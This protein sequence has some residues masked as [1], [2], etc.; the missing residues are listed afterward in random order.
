M[1]PRLGACAIAIGLAACGTPGEPVATAPA[2]ARAFEW[3]ELAS[4]PSARTEVA[5]AVDGDGLIVVVGGFAPDTVAT[6]EIYDPSTDRWVAGPA[7]PIAVNHAMAASVDGVVHVFGGYTS[8]GAPSNQAFALRGGSWETLPV[9]PEGRAAGG[10]A[11]AGGLVY[12]AG[13]VGP[14]GLAAS[15]LIFDPSTDAWTSGPALLRPREH[16]GVASVGSSVYAVG[17]RT[18]AGNLADAEI[19]E[20]STGA[21]RRLPDMPTARGGLSAAGTANGFV[22]APGG[23]DL[24][25]G[26]TTFAE[27]EALDTERERWVSLPSMPSPR[28]GL[29]VVAIGDV[30]YTIAGGPTPGLSTADTLEAI[31]LTQLDTLDCLRRSPTA[32]GAP[33]RDEIDGTD[34]RDVIA[35]LGG[36]DALEGGGGADRLCGGGSEDRLSGGPGKDRLHGGA[37]RD[38]CKEPG[39]DSRRQRCER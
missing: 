11:T 19:F 28:H 27:V 13:G 20:P 24:G 18:G 21:W 31:D 17:G 34:G 3:H 6:V 26:G 7:L 8:G 12:I 32:V 14:S 25:P 1:R 36:P 22:V 35:S 30:V 15:T 33:S 10:A 37:G 29:G 2:E 5:A 38:R 4:A 9:M 23:E 16:L 39:P